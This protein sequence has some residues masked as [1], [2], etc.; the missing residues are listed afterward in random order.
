MAALVDD[1]DTGVEG[2]LSLESAQLAE[3]LIA[4]ADRN[5]YDTLNVLS[6]LHAI[7]SELKE[8]Q[9]EQM[10]LNTNQLSEVLAA[11]KDLKTTMQKGQKTAI[12]Q[13]AINHAD[14]APW[15]E[16]GQ[17]SDQ[18]N[19]SCSRSTD[20][21]RHILMAFMQGAGS[22]ISGC[23]AGSKGVERWNQDGDTWTSATFEE[24][25]TIHIHTI[26]GT[27]PRIT[28]TKDGKRCIWYE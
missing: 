25:I 24:K 21:V 10:S 4:A 22:Y 18:R 7:T 14:L 13:W 12:I 8:D 15:F 17:E 28:S 3:A 26:T 19:Q 2:A 5:A 9:A 6:H 20:K 23:V 1:G 16:F 27:K 11:V